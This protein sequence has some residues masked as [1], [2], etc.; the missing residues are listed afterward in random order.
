[1]VTSI[2]FCRAASAGVAI[3]SNSISTV[4]GTGQGLKIDTESLLTLVAGGIVFGTPKPA[5]HGPASPPGSTFRLYSDREAAEEATES[6]RVP[7]GLFFPGS[8]RGVSVGTSVELRGI[9]VGTSPNWS[10]NT[11]PVTSPT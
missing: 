9:A 7:Y 4:T 1:L 3:R 6:V 10:S 5:L 8:L 11:W 2:G